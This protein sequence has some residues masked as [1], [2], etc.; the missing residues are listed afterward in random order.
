MKNPGI[1]NF[2]RVWYNI[3]VLWDNS[4]FERKKFFGYFVR[5]GRKRIIFKMRKGN[6]SSLSSK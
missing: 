1:F 5:D 4:P 6:T 2:P 3:E